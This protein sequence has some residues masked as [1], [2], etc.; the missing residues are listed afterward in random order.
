MAVKITLKM[1]PKSSPR[2]FVTTSCIM[3]DVATPGHALVAPRGV[4][5]LGSAIYIYIYIYRPEWR[6]CIRSYKKVPKSD[7][8][9]A[10]NEKKAAMKTQVNNVRLAF[11]CSDRQK[12]M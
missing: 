4:P 3:H 9:K 6:G 5:T 8:P 7:L 10:A 2:S 12:P 11:G 1:T